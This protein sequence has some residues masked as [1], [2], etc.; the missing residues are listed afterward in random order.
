MYKKILFIIILIPLV[1][2]LFGC[3][4]VRTKPAYYAPVSPPPGLI[5]SLVKAPLTYNFKENPVG[6]S[7]KKMTCTST[8]WF[9]IPVYNYEFAFG[10]A[11][12]GRIAMKEGIE[13]VSYADYQILTVLGIFAKFTVNI[14]G[15]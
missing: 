2:V 5:F 13:K 3:S 1:V 7:V 11:D 6:D 9:N 15:N 14:Y 8:L 12:I 10:N 4:G